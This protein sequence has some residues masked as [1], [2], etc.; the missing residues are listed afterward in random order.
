MGWKSF[1]VFGKHIDCCQR[2][3][4]NLKILVYLVKF[5]NSPNEIWIAGRIF[6]INIICNDKRKDIEIPKNNM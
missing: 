5:F 4:K 6:K 2:L 1:S 3:S